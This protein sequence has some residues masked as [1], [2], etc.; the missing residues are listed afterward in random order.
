MAYVSKQDK[1]NL[2]PVI[3]AVLKKYK[4]KGTI[5]I[6]HYS[7]LVVKV[8]AGALDFSEYLQTGEWP[9]DHLDVNTYWIDEHYKGNE[10]IKNFLNELHE[11]MKGPD[12]YDNTDIMTDYFDRSHYTDIKVGTYDK[13]YRH[14]V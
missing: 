14:V 2:A 9:R 10:Q 12:F 3:K 11:A 5:S 7:T 13:P 6:Q 4:M 1:A 8:A